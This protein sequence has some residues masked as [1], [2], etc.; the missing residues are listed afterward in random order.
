MM[1]CISCHAETELNF[2]LAGGDLAM[3]SASVLSVLASDNS[4]VTRSLAYF[5]TSFFNLFFKSLFC[6]F[7]DFSHFCTIC[8]G[9]LITSDIY[10]RF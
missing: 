2:S 4:T 8:I 3:P 6:L 5:L 1:Q 9:T 7:L 10:Y